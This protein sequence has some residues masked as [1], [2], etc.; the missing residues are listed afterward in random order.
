MDTRTL[1]LLTAGAFVVY[2]AYLNPAVGMAV[3]VGVGVVALL[4][5]LIKK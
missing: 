4:E 2:I 5:G 1:G 3:V